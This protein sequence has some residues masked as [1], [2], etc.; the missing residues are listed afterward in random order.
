MSSRASEFH[1]CRV[2]VSGYQTIAGACSRGELFPRTLRRS[3]S[4]S[5]AMTTTMLR[6]YSFHLVGP[7][8]S[9]NALGF[10]LISDDQPDRLRVEERTSG[11]PAVWLH[12]D[13]I[14]GSLSISE[15]EIGRGLPINSITSWSTSLLTLGVL[16]HGSR[17]RWSR[18]SRC[19]AVP[20]CSR[21]IA[22]L[23]RPSRSIGRTS[24]NAMAS[25]DD[26]GRNANLQDKGLV[27]NAG[28][29]CIAPAGRSPDWIKVNNPTSPANNLH[30]SR[31][32]PPA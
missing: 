1:F 15:R 26:G 32:N 13:G 10:R 24:S 11:P 21:T 29:A 8:P 12:P 3:P 30:G 28:K 6:R 17:K 25:G 7:S 20:L 2:F 4:I 18:L 14:L 19:A 31:E 22:V 9:S 5:P 16:M 27:S 23:A